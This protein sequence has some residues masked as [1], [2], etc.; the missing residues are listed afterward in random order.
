MG[1][2]MGLR[3]NF[4]G[5][6]DALNYHPEYWQ[7][8]T[9]NGQ[10]HYCTKGTWTG[11][12]FDKQPLDA[13]TLHTNG[14]DCVGPR[15]V[16]PITDSE[17]NGLIWKWGSS[18]VMD[19][20]GDVT[21]DMNDIGLY[22]KAAMRFG[23]TDVV[24]IDTDTNVTLSCAAG[25]TCSTGVQNTSLGHAADKGS[26]YLQ[27]LD[28]FGG[29]F[30]QTVGSYHYSTYADNFGIL[31]TCG[32]QTDPNNPL[33]ATCSGPPIDYVARRDMVDVQKFG[34]A[35]SNAFA[36]VGNAGALT[37]NFSVYAPN[38]APSG[39]V[40]HPYMFGSDEF[41]DIG[42]VP[43]YRFDAGADQYEQI[44]FLVSTY[45]NRYIFDNFRRDRTT[46]DT[47]AQVSRAQS[48]YFDKVQ[49]ITKALALAVESYGNPTID[50]SQNDPTIT[51]PAVAQFLHDPGVADADGARC[52]WTA[53]RC[54]SGS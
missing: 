52:A 25:K 49:Q 5:S 47:H 35:Q 38:G 2:S 7:L 1:H 28:G 44:Q 29:I 41:A 32:N 54:G 23:Y 50:P 11:Q 19:Y 42:S 34:Q 46:F 4:T 16:D 3:H 37:A 13:E 9:R 22:D 27:V 36:A 21:Q 18:T 14:T 31:G 45:E 10:E 33:S 15:W 26:A 30:G 20:P 43:V 6:I 17:V 53:S 24:D 51:N 40:R 12:A 48:R 39:A 8:R